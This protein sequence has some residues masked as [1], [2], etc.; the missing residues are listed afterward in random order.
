MLQWRF[1]CSTSTHTHTHVTARDK[2]ATSAVAGKTF[3][4]K[5]AQQNHKTSLLPSNCGQNTTSF[6]FA[7]ANLGFESFIMALLVFLVCNLGK[8]KE[9]SMIKMY[10]QY[11][12]VCGWL[13]DAGY[14]VLWCTTMAACQ[15][16]RFC[17]FVRMYAQSL[18]YY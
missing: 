4:Q 15:H 1:A 2:N 6:P 8:L 5:R 7:I 14:T 13:L 10:T 11:Y 18:L 12:V 17:R 3:R 16:V 9:T